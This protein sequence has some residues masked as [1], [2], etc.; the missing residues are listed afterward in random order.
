M[1]LTTAELH[2]FECGSTFFAKQNNKSNH[3]DWEARRFELVKELSAA[4]LNKYGDKPR[5]E[6]VESAIQLADAIISRLK[7]KS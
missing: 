6:F 4:A 3:I 2:F 1:P 5:E 7:E